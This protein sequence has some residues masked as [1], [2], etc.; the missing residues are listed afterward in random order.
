MGLNMKEKQAV[1]AVV[2]N[3]EYQPRYQKAGK[4]VKSALLDEFTRLTGYHRKSAIRL[5]RRKPVREVLVRGNGKAVKF[6]PEKKR[7]ANRKGKR[8]YTDEVIA[9]LR[10]VWTFFRYKCGKI[11]APLMR[12]I[13]DWPAFHITAEIAAKLETISPATIDRYL[14]KDKEALKLKGKSLTKPPASLKSRIP[15]RAFYTADERRFAEPPTP[16]FWQ[17]DTVHHCG[18]TTAGQ[19]AHTL[20]A[21]DAAFGWLELRSLLNNAHS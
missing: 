4:K 12:Y 21:T 19:Y 16:G 5:L 14:K 11:L 10:L 2:N 6:K 1:T 18:Q 20:T 3:R 17:I 15:I 8:I 9:S 7:P 13:A